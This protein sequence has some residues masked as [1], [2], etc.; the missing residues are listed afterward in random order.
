[1]FQNAHFTWQFGNHRNSGLRGFELMNRIVQPNFQGRC[2]QR[3]RRKL[4]HT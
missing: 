3:Q 4:G 1:M 2:R